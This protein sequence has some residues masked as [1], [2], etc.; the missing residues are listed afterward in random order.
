MNG[1]VSGLKVKSLA[2]IA[3]AL[4]TELLCLTAD[5]HI[6]SGYLNKMYWPVIGLCSSIDR[7]LEIS[8]KGLGLDLWSGVWTPW[9]D[10]Q[11]FV[12]TKFDFLKICCR[13]CIP[14]YVRENIPLDRPDR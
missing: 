4:A 7:M 13:V 5:Q 14:S 10:H 11:T 12:L 3:N 6:S 8:V 9:G 2:W 1:K